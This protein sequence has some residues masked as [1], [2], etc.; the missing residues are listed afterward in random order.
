MK[1]GDFFETSRDIDISS[2]VGKNNKKEDEQIKK[3]DQKKKK[4]TYEIFKAEGTLLRTGK[5]KERPINKY[6]TGFNP[7]T[8]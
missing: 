6:T 8:S 4:K 7:E 2:S 3:K 1:V 5:A